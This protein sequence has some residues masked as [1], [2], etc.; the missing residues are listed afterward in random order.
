MPISSE[1][2]AAVSRLHVG[3]IVVFSNSVQAVRTIVLDVINDGSG[4]DRLVLSQLSTE[5]SHIPFMENGFPT[6]WKV[7][8]DSVFRTYR[9]RRPFPI[10][11]T[12]S[13]SVSVVKFDP[14]SGLCKPALLY[15]RDRHAMTAFK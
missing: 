11:E 9:N 5:P 7:A 12:G 15:Q 10:Q 8:L 6:E 13:T 4:Y 1:T 14:K 2:F 3:D